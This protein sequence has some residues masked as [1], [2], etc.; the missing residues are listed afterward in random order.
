MRAIHASCF[1]HLFSEPKQRV[2]A[3]R[4]AARLPHLQFDAASASISSADVA[5]LA[6]VEHP[7]G[8]G[9]GLF[10]W[11]ALW[12]KG[13]AV[14]R[15][16]FVVTEDEQGAPAADEALSEAEQEAVRVAEADAELY[17]AEAAAR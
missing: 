10:D 12:D 2:I 11:R 14:E 9:V 5:A 7:H 4:L 6:P 13:D 16:E 3:H 17:H 8:H 15:H 1:F